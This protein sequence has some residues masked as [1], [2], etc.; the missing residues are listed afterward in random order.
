MTKM[1]YKKR[2]IG[3]LLLIASI[4]FFIFWELIGRKQLLFKTVVVFKEDIKE[5]VKITYDLLTTNKVEVDNCILNVIDNPKII[6]GKESK[7]FIPAKTQLVSQ[8]FEESI[9]N[10]T[11]GNK[12][13]KFPDEWLYSFPQTIRRKDR[14]YIYSIKDDKEV[15]KKDNENIKNKKHFIFE[16][17]VAYAKDN[18]N[19][20]VESLDL[21][22]LN[23][24]SVV[25]NIEIITTD[26]QYKILLDLIKKG[27]K[28]IIMY[29]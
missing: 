17:I 8:Y 6:V 1:L 10:L 16:T 26:N 2:I 27:Y 21:D 24:S 28:F 15:N 18:N 11:N 22:R 23:G 9:L 3:I 14:I 5:G 12:I 25:S 20:E 13:M 7:H 4:V 19:R 29:K